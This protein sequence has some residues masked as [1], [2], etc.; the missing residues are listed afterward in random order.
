MRAL[1]DL[2]S[3]SWCRD[4]LAGLKVLHKSD[5]VHNDLSARN[6]FVELLDGR[7]ILKIGD[8]G[9]AESVKNKPNK[10]TQ[11]VCRMIGPPQS[12][13]SQEN[14][15]YS[16]PHD[17]YCVGRIVHMVF[18]LELLDNDETA[19]T[20]TDLSNKYDEIVRTTVRRILDKLLSVDAASRPSASA[21][22]GQF[23]T[24]CALVKQLR[25]S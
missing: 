11:R 10:H 14:K 25:S 16:F 22:H 1:D 7:E 12:P 18:A 6:V 24:L 8:Y 4:M 5:I 21:A 2:R 9:L 23:E 17:V 3:V 15:G 20:T 13:E 19:S